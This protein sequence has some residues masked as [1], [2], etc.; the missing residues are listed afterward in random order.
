MGD[1]VQLGADRRIDGRMPVAVDVAP[2]GADTIQIRRPSES[3][4]SAP[5]ARSITSG[6][7]ACQSAWAVKGCQR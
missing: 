3:I 1:L 6:S 5:S 2:K 4:N 7:P